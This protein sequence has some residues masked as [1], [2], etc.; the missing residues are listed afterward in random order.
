MKKRIL[1]AALCVL[2]LAALFP[3]S[4]ARADDGLSFLAIND[5]LPPELINVV[6]YYGGVGYV[7]NWLLTNY[8][9]GFYYSYISSNSTAYLSTSDRQL[10]FELTTGKTYDNEDNEY[11]ATAIMW[12][13]TVYF[14]LEFVSYYY[15]LF[16]VRMIGSNEYGSVLRICNGSEVLSD[17]I[18]F[19]AADS[20]MKRYYQA[21]KNETEPSP[22]PE[23]TSGP[24]PTPEP[25]TPT[26]KP[27][28]E[29]D[30][31]HLGLEGMPTEATLELLRSQGIR[32]CFFLNGRE[33]TENPDMVR[34][35]ACEGYTLGVSSRGERASETQKTADLLWETARIC[36][37]LAAIPA[38]DVAPDGMVTFP[39][40]RLDPDKA[41]DPEE[42]IYTVTN[43]LELRAGDQ[44]LIF[45]T[46]GEDVAALRMLLYYLS[47]LEFSVI[48]IR[49]TDGG[50]T[51]IIP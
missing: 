11:Q 37:I 46:G 8:G 22:E 10:Y 27:S 19:R 1:A 33:I 7:P 5:Y 51:P 38:G 26:E 16:S 23:P 41:Q 3:G 49:E 21:W 34:R 4:A 6:V 14:P 13:G 28:R 36:T 48:P 32:V 40:V 18:F 20:A 17:D 2:L 25:P 47:D 30:T 9:L 50:G 35:L 44:T 39:S 43:K 42:I 15:G 29:G 24:E 12:G 45:P 31:I